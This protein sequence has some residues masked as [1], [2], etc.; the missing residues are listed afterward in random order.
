MS[1]V[2]ISHLLWNYMT[3]FAISCNQSLLYTFMFHIHCF[4]TVGMSLPEINICQGICLPIFLGVD[5]LDY[6][7]MR[8]RDWSIHLQYLPLSVYFINGHVSSV[9]SLDILYFP[10][11]SMSWKKWM[12]RLSLHVMIP[13]CMLLSGQNPILGMCT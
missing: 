11:Y 13:C 12:L 2:P 9:L 1:A 3:A 7:A 5:N 8:I 4:L 10:I 6:W